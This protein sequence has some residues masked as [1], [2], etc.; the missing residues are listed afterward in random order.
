MTESTEEI[1]DPA[2]VYFV[3]RT[4]TIE[5]HLMTRRPAVRSEWFENFG[6][7]VRDE[8]VWRESWEENVY[9]LEP[10][11]LNDGDGYVLDIGAN[12]GA[13]TALCL[14][15]NEKI[16]VVAVEP[17]E[18][19]LTLL[20]ETVSSNGWNGRTTIIPTALSNYDGV[21][22]MTGGGGAA[23][24]SGHGSGATPVQRPSTLIS[25][26]GRDLDWNFL[27]MDCEGS[28]FR[29]IH[30]LAMHNLLDRF[31]WV[32][33]EFHITKESVFGRML[34]EICRTHSISGII[35]QASTGGALWAH[36]ND[37]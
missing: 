4:V 3:E 12:I 6:G 22:E 32:A 37:V 28:E 13:F 34:A 9:R 2:G 31:R 7:K 8:I 19:N 14:A 23:F 30:D 33:M 5:R 18:D 16:H 17:I 21:C 20:H 27:K 24:V 26:L 36:R 1:E 29:I 10:Y 35:G 15:M 25:E 11:M